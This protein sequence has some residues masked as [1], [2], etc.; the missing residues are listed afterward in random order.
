MPH[1]NHTNSPAYRLRQIA[2]ETCATASMPDD[3]RWMFAQSVEYIAERLQSSATYAH[4]AGLR[5]SP[6][7][8]GAKTLANRWLNDL[9]DAGIVPGGVWQFVLGLFGKSSIQSWILSEL[10]Q[11]AMQWLT[12]NKSNTGNA[13]AS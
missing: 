9:I 3:R 1:S 8:A 7:E 2:F 13:R 11:L 12:S 5:I 4:T 6:T 10:I